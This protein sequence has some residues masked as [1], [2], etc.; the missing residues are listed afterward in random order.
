MNLSKLF[1][2]RCCYL[3]FSV[4]MSRRQNN[5]AS[6]REVVSMPYD[7]FVCVSMFDLDD[8]ISGNC[9]LLTDIGCLAHQTS[10]ESWSKALVTRST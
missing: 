2:F 5:K 1:N 10:R 3:N 4:V 8:A 7:V 9:A 6:H